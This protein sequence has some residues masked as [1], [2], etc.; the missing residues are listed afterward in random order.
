MK[1]LLSVNIIFTHAT[2]TEKK[3]ANCPQKLF[4]HYFWGC[5]CLKKKSIYFLFFLSKKTFLMK[6]NLQCTCQVRYRALMAQNSAQ[7]LQGIT[8]CPNWRSSPACNFFL[9]KLWLIL[10]SKFKTQFSPVV[11]FIIYINISRLAPHCS[12]E[13]FNTDK[14]NL[15]FFTGI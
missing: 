4:I 7:F 15:F 8:D 9:H 1:Y 14:N 6:M 12:R 11:S 3:S 10:K 13:K 2:E 5:F